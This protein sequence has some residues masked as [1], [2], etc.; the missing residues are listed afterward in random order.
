[1]EIIYLRDAR[2]ALKRLP[3]DLRRKFLRA[4]ETPCVNLCGVLDLTGGFVLLRIIEGLIGPRSPQDADP[5]P[6]KDA[7]G[8]GMVTA[9]CSG[10]VV[11]VGRPGGGV[12]RVVGEAGNG[13]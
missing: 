1:M 8:L 3:A 2:N 4:F 5:G 7:N 13:L 9:A 12:A 6:G 10:L 11:K